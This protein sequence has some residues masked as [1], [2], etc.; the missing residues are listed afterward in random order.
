MTNFSKIEA[1]LLLQ[2]RVQSVSKNDLAARS[3]T[4]METLTR[5][6][7]SRITISPIKTVLLYQPIPKYREIDLS[8]L[9]ESF[10]DIHFDQAP[11]NSGGGFPD[12][13]YDMIFVPIYGFNGDKYRLGHGAGWYDRF[14]A[15][16]PEAIKIG[17]GLD[18]GRVYFTPEP[19]DVPMDIIVTESTQKLI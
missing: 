14:L 11:Q 3:A 12:A 4:I 13:T 18:I 15:S 19:H 2:S 1:R 16:Q 7:S 6:I 9:Q 17:V 10:P 8:A 5:F